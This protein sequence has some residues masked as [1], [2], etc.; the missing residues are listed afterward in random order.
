MQNKEDK[1]DL[2]YLGL[3]TMNGICRNASVE[4]LIET[5]LHRN[6]GKLGRNGALMVDTG[7]YTGRSPKDRFIVDEPSTSKNVW[8]GPVNQKTTKKSF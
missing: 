8:W 5:A 6:E 4:L 7:K 1:L 2:S 3:N